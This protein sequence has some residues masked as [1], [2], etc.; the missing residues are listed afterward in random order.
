MKYL[1]YSIL[2]LLFLSNCTPKVEFTSPNI[3]FLREINNSFK[4]KSIPK[5]SK[6]NILQKKN[7]DI[8]QKK[9]QKVTKPILFFEKSNGK[10]GF[11]ALYPGE[12]LNETWYSSDGVNISLFN[13]ELVS[14]R[15]LRNNL[16]DTSLPRLKTYGQRSLAPYSKNQYFI[17]P[18]NKIV[19]FSFSCT[20]SRNY[21]VNSIEIF[22]QK[23]EIVEYI[24]SCKNNKYIIVNKLW[25]SLEG[26]T[27]KTLQWHSE[28][29][30]YITFTRLNMHAEQ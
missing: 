10:S 30:G 11:L 6:K 3:D 16:I 2:S 17:T 18:E 12:N 26:F 15:G 27:I 4:F 1:I 13:G 21:D 8:P 28:S 7:S 23:Y 24:E 22:N 5:N 29:L 19:E 14:T 20:M 25:Q 9:F